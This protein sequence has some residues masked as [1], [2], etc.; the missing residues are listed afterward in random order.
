M[1]KVLK[2]SRVLWMVGFATVAGWTIT[3][4][5]EDFQT[6]SQKTKEVADKF[7]AAPAAIGKALQN[8]KDVTGAKLQQSFGAKPAP[9]NNANSSD[10]PK[11]K[12][13]S[14]GNERFSPAGKRDP[15]RP[16][17]LTTKTTSE[18][19]GNLSPLERFELGQL[20]VV[21]IVWD[22]KEPRAMIEDTGGLGYI[23]KVGTPIGSSQ[24]RVKA[25][26][27][28]EVVVEESYAD[29]SGIKK[30]RDVSLKLPTE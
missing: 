15:F 5:Q 19:R 24:G 17:S 29:F 4:A 28:N 9:D 20:K 22:V 8:L 3:S 12:T 21:G 27:R 14:P 7:N 10:L 11:T 26:Y 18:A 6:P 23:V 2:I 1:G 30:K 25:I 16:L 13:E